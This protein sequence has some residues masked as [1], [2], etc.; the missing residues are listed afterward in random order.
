M[1]CLLIYKTAWG[2]TALTLLVSRIVTDDHNLAVATNHLAVVTD[3]LDTRLYLHG[4]T[5]TEN[6]LSVGFTCSGKRCVRATG[7]TG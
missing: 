5:S 7:R 1:K 3:L 2:L 6:R 4:S